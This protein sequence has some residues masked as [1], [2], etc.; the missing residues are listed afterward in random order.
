MP[1]FEPETN[2]IP[3]RRWR[4]HERWWSLA[5]GVVIGVGLGMVLYVLVAHLWR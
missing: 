1:L 4:R 3:I 5:I 2:V